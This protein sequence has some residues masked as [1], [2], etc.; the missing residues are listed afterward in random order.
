MTFGNSPTLFSVDA[1]KKKWKS[2][3]DT[4]GQVRAKMSKQTGSAGGTPKKLWKH[5]EK[6]GFVFEVVDAKK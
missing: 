6:M 5:F 2:L 1:L 4:I 3:K